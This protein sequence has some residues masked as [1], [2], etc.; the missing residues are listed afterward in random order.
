MVKLNIKHDGFVRVINVEPINALRYSRFTPCEREWFLDAVMDDKCISPDSLISF[1][2]N[3]DVTSSAFR[4]PSSPIASAQSETVEEVA[5]NDT[6]QEQEENIMFADAEQEVGLVVGNLNVDSTYNQGMQENASLA[7][8]MSR[9]VEI[10]RRTWA[11]GAVTPFADA[12]NPWELFLNDPRVLNKLDT[13]KLLRAT[14][15]LKF[16]IN[17]SPYH[18]GRVFI[19]CRPTKFDNNTTT[20]N[21]N[22]VRTSTN[23]FD[24]LG[25]TQERFAKVMYSQRPH[26][27]IDPATNQP[28]HIDWPYFAATNYLDLTDPDAIDRLGRLEIWEF[29]TLQHNNGA[30]DPLTITAFAWLEDVELTGLTSQAIAVAQSDMKKSKSKKKKG[31]VMPESKNKDE[32][33]QNGMISGPASAVADYANY[34]MEI[35]VIGDFARATHIA[36]GA[37]ADIARLFGFSRPAIID[38]PCVLR[39][40]TTSNM[41]TFSG[42]DTLFKLAFDPK[43]ELTIDPGSVGLPSDDQMAIG[44]IAKKEA[45]IGSFTW[46]SQDVTERRIF[47][48]LVHPMVR[49]I[50]EVTGTDSYIYSQTPIS[51]VTTP[52]SYWRGSL[53]YRF[54]IVASAF[55][56]GRLAV[57]Y[58]PGTPGTDFDLN[59]RYAVILDLAEAKDFTIEVKWSQMQAYCGTTL[60]PATPVFVKEFP[61]IMANVPNSNGILNV[62]VMNE[63]A[64]S[65]TT[66]SVE[67]NVF[68]SAG[69]DYQLQMPNDN[70]KLL[71]YSRNTEP[72][73]PPAF[74]Q[75]EV[76]TS[77][78]ND[79]NQSSMTVINGGSHAMPDPRSNLVYFGE[80]V[81]SIRSLMKRYNFHRPLTNQGLTA[82]VLYSLAYN[83]FNF[84]VGPGKTYGS[85]I[86]SG[87]DTISG[88]STYNVVAMTHLRFFCQSYIGWRGSLRYKMINIKGQGDSGL[89]KVTRS[90]R[91]ITAE[92]SA[93]LILKTTGTSRLSLNQGYLSSNANSNDLEGTNIN[94]ALVNP[95]IEYELPMYHTFRYVEV[96]EPPNLVGAQDKYQGNYGGGGHYVTMLARN[97]DTKS[98]PILESHVSIGEDFSFFFFIGASPIFTS[99][100][101]VV[102]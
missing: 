59:N 96:N 5:A 26:V 76:I 89:I 22:T 62:Y 48:I 70:I 20:D 91:P 79:P 35:P 92:T 31:K 82:D 69:D 29:N 95:T 55:H 34:F 23:Y 85:S 30:T 46:D 58:D 13:F 11:V 71:S 78:E 33:Q 97:T 25:V 56:R 73:G 6:S 42:G 52:F 68:L 65:I 39:P 40:Q 54:Q 90:S 102:V 77:Q 16:Q 12:I 1:I 21:I 88:L 80:Q 51:M 18:Y 44:F 53:R 9:P 14:L 57:V 60:L 50:A 10:Y 81:V 19:G 93:A 17:G 72:V 8:F 7:T 84:P 98:F 87:T 74:A 49:P 24:F 27:F 94:S 67:V 61:A 3:L 32:Y 100:A 83:I 66:S 45:Y 86:V 2:Y 99:D 15:K 28:M 64:S 36:S 63:L 4:R 101:L 41:A 38:D 43:Q 37:V 47:A 75:S